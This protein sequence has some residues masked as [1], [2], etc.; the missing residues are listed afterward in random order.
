MF[1]FQLFKNIEVLF[2][3]VGKIFM[4]NCFIIVRQFKMFYFFIN[5]LLFQEKWGEGGGG[6]W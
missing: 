1:I 4:V 5:K 3:I 6:S 2:G